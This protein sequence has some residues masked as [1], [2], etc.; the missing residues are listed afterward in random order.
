M[1]NIGG[2]F[3]EIEEFILHPEYNEDLFSNNDVAVFRI[4]GEFDGINMRAIEM[5]DTEP[6]PNSM[7]TISGWG[8][9][10]VR[11]M[12]RKYPLDYLSAISTQLSLN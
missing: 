6:V 7:V 12:H 2:K 4:V 3:Y 8:N 1:N 9:L 11:L 5:G 10:A